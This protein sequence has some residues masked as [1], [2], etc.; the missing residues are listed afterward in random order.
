MDLAC[1][2]NFLHNRAV[3]TS[4]SVC[5]SSKIFYCITGCILDRGNARFVRFRKNSSCHDHVKVS[6]GSLPEASSEGSQAPFFSVT[7]CST[8]SYSFYRIS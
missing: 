8:L 4:K 2:E 3:A 1:I 6:K 5:L 7:S